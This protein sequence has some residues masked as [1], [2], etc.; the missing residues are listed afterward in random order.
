LN[1]LKPV[2]LR[3]IQDSQRLE[4]REMVQ[5]GEQNDELST[6]ANISLPSNPDPD[7]SEPTTSKSKPTKRK[8]LKPKQRNA[9]TS[10]FVKH[11]DSSS[12]SNHDHDKSKDIRGGPEVPLVATN[13]NNEIS[14][15]LETFVC[16]P[17]K[18]QSFP[19]RDLL[20][21]KDQVHSHELKALRTCDLCNINDLMKTNHL[22]QH[23][24]KFHSQ[25][26]FKKG[27]PK[28]EVIKSNHK[29][30]N[31]DISFTSQ[32]S[33]DV[34][35]DSSISVGNISMDTSTINDEIFENSLNSSAETVDKISDFLSQTVPLQTDD[36]DVP[37][38]GGRSKKPEAKQR[39]RS[40]GGAMKATPKKAKKSPR[41]NWTKKPKQ[42]S[43]S[44]VLAPV[45]SDND[46]NH[47]TSSGNLRKKG[48]HVHDQSMDCSSCS[49]SPR[50]K[51]PNAREYETE[52]I[53]D[54]V[55]KTKGKKRG[56]DPVVEEDKIIS[57]SAK[58][59]R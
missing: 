54:S 49:L 50:E 22:H 33:T 7:Q 4:L 44:K 32:A 43:K 5:Q 21:H 1:H 59:L 46:P 10:K 40:L 56:Q 16:H 39:S 58:K 17:C 48:R 6:Q 18:K 2:H 24:K 31:D 13:S 35:D 45:L 57:I 47:P 14:G 36:V 20:K 41:K 8:N 26:V 30:L 19:L 12:F 3:K 52:V 37:K 9:S 23:R 27:R 15:E 34:L 28:K 25:E 11:G 38:K 53:K 55:K 42:A 51:L 29:A